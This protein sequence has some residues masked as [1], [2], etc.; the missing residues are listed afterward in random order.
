MSEHDFTSKSDFSS[1][2]WKEDI[3]I[4]SIIDE[5]RGTKVLIIDINEFQPKQED[6]WDHRYRTIQW[7]GYHAGLN[8]VSNGSH[9]GKKLLYVTEDVASIAITLLKKVFVMFLVK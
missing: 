8:L 5:K 6:G 9:P 4:F 2:E 3:N 7:R 1:L